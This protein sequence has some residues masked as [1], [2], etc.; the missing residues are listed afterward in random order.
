MIRIL[1]AM[2]AVLL[3]PQ[4][5][6]AQAR[7]EPR[8]LIVLLEANPWLMAVGSDSPAFAL[9]DDGQVIYRTRSGYKSVKLDARERAALIERV[10]PQALARVAGHYD[11]LANVSDQPTEYL[12][13]F[14]ADGPKAVSVYGSLTQVAKLVPAPIGTAYAALH[15]Y[16][17]PRA[18]DWLPDKIEVLIWP[19]EYAPEESILWPKGWPGLGHPETVKRD[20]GAYSLFLP[21]SRSRALTALLQTRRERG[22]VRIDG[23]KW[24]V[25]YRFPFP[26]EQS[27]NALRGREPV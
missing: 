2:I 15:G 21:A 17:H 4:A 16:Q 9:Y 6:A 27:W 8:P 23:R 26:Q 10:Q 5:A 24:A 22:A 14:G 1:L 11:V 3:L 19:Y 18:R 20:E 12:F 25:S 13:V 7:A